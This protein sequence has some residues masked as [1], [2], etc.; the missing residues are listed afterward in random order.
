MSLDYRIWIDGYVLVTSNPAQACAQPATLLKHAQNTPTGAP[1]KTGQVVCGLQSC[2]ASCDVGIIDRSR[3]RRFPRRGHIDGLGRRSLSFDRETGAMLERVHL[4]R[5]DLVPFESIIRDRASS[6][7]PVVRR[8]TLSPARRASNATPS[9]GELTVLAEF[10]TGSRLSDLL[11]ATAD[12]GDRSRR[13]RRAGLLCSTA[14]PALTLPA[15][16]RRHHARPDR[17]LTHCPHTRRTGRVSRR[18]VWY[19]QSS[20][21]TCRVSGCGPGFGIAVARGR[22][23]RASRSR[24]PTSPRSR[25]APLRSCSDATCRPD[26]YPERA[27][28]RSSWKSIEVAQIRGTAAFATG[29]PALPPALAAASR[30]AG[31]IASADEA[32]GRRSAT[33]APRHRTSTCAARPSMEFAAQMDAALR[34]RAG[35]G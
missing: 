24:R 23:C 9:T 27:D 26:E 32:L 5:R 2:P 1:H 10:V 16:D 14:L 20:T 31:R 3:R 30:A 34:H 13:R 17:R 19:R 29:S 4:R 12:A 25:S 18:R 21:S 28:H 35:R 6:R 33:R 8:R 15:L 22:W 11:E 7:L